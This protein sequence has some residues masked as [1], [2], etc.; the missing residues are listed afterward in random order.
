M[1]IPEL[2]QLDGLEVTDRYGADPYAQSFDRVRMRFEGVEF[3]GVGDE[4]GTILFL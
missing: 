4:S 2:E 1:T 3:V